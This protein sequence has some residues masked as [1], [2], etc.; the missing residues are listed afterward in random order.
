MARSRKPAGSDIQLTGDKA[1]G[2]EIAAIRARFNE[3]IGSRDIDAIAEALAENCWLVP[4]DEADPICGRE[5][6]LDAWSS[7][8]GQSDDA[9]YTRSPQ[10]IEI[11][12]DGGLAAE[13]GRWRGGWTSE[14]FEIRYTGRYFAKWR[15]DGAAWRI[16]SETFVTLKRAGGPV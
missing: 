7:I 3:A 9:S 1:A 16:E 10:R 6:Q 12:E 15:F 14:G 8:F 13:T 2:R 11:S 5:A 4:G